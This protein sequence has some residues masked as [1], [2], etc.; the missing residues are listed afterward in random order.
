MNLSARD[1]Y[2]ETQVLT[3]TPQRLRLMLIEAAL[4]KAKV[5]QQAC[6]ANDKE[7]A[8]AA[9]SYCRDIISELIA[10][11]QPDQSPLAKQVLG[12]YMFVYS[13]LVE[14]GLT[15]DGQRLRD[16]MRVLDEERQT[17]QAVCEQMP[18]RPV[19]TQP[20]PVAEELAPQRVAESWTGGYAG[21]PHGRKATAGELSLEA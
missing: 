2:L 11:L 19:A 16:V 1:A 21:T 18:E 8:L 17:W 5:A 14:I 20:A 13:V 15:V 12:I 10:G 3:A 9:I 6:D 4:R 7:T